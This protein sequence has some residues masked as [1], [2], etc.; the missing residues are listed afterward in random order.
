[1]KSKK[2][3]TILHTQYRTTLIPT[4]ISP[5]EENGDVRKRGDQHQEQEKVNKE[6]NRR[7][8]T[9]YHHEYMIRN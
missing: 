2:S 9:N 6:K 3:I 7:K 1:M 4:L 8:N 5:K